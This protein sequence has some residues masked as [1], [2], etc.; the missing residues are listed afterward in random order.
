LR[1]FALNTTNVKK[2]VPLE[3]L[4][5]AITQQLCILHLLLKPLMLIRAAKAIP[6]TIQF[7]QFL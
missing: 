6:E 5:A 3:M 1:V 4:I 2:A 7:L